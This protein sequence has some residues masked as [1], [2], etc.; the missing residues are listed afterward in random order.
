MSRVARLVKYGLCL[1]LSLACV[2][3]VAA[4]EPEFRDTVLRATDE[5]VVLDAEIVFDLT[6][7][8]E[9]AVKRGVA[10]Y[11][12]LEFEL[13]RPRWYWFDE[14]IVAR[15]QTWRLSYHALTRKYRLSAGALHM[16]FDTL[17]EA[18]SVMRH[19]RR[20]GVAERVQLRPGESY[21]AG[22]R[23]RLDSTQL[24]TPFQVS[25]IGSREWTLDSGWQRW[26]YFVST[27]S[28]R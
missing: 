9:E 4:A 15:S 28:A 18:V 27:E 8:L 5:G 25:A 7:R 6:P 24:P 2:L 19:V 23:F 22:V 16:S 12:V 10:L 26:G 1:L 14:K 17:G 13:I 20:W 21:Q 11:F 3:E